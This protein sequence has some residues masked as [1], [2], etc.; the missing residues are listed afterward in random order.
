MNSPPIKAVLAAISDS[1]SLAIRYALAG[2]MD[3]ARKWRDHSDKLF[4]KA[5]N[6]IP[7]FPQYI[8]D[9]YPIV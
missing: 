5:W 2:D 8:R 3:E 4:T 1:D 7:D 6:S 9:T